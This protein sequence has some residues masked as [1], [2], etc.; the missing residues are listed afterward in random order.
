MMMPI[1]NIVIDFIIDS[2]DISYDMIDITI[3]LLMVL[4]NLDD[5]Q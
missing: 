3:L 1:K 4:N 2:Y 5:E